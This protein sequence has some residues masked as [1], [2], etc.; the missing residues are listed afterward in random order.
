VTKLHSGTAQTATFV[1]L[2]THLQQR[3]TLSACPY[4][5]SCR[6]WWAHCTTLVS[7]WSAYAKPL[8]IPFEDGKA[9]IPADAWCMDG[10]YCGQP[11]I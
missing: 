5:L 8:P 4:N 7:L 6:S 10:S 1:K 11:A 9:P 3:G 2:G